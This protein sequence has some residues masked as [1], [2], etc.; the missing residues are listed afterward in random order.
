[1]WHAMAKFAGGKG[2]LQTRHLGAY[3][4]AAHEFLHNLIMSWHV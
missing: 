4:G 2:A 1:M 3:T